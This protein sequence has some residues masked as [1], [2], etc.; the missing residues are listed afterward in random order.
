MVKSTFEINGTGFERLFKSN[1]KHGDKTLSSGYITAYKLVIE[2]EFI[3]IFTY[4]N[5][6]SHEFYFVVDEVKIDGNIIL[7]NKFTKVG[8]VQTNHWMFPDSTNILKYKYVRSTETMHIVFK[9]NPYLKYVYYDVP[10]YKYASMLKVR[11][12]GGYYCKNIKGVYSWDKIN[13]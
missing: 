8:R 10:E 7:P 11:S 1:L 5:S 6:A 3:M 13:L 12:K 4:N 9:S 2:Q